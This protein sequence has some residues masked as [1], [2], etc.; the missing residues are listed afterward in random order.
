MPLMTAED[1]LLEAEKMIRGRRPQSPRVGVVLGS[2]LGAFG[3][4]LSDLSKVPYAEVPHMPRSTVVGHA[5]NLCLGRVGEVEVACLQ[6]RVH[7]Y[8]GHDLDTV[9]FGVKLLARLGC[10]AVIL[11]NA[12]GGVNTDFAPGD[13]MLITDH[14]NLTAQNPLVG[15]NPE[16]LPRFP[17]MTQAYDE[18]ILEAGRRAAKDAGSPLREGVYATMLGPSYETPTEIRML[19]TL[20][21]DAVGMSTVVEVLAL[22]HRAVRVGA[23]SCI[24]NLAAGMSGG[25]LD[26][27]EVEEVATRT[28]ERFVRVLGR[29]VELTGGL[30]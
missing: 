12:A 4:S 21:A 16:G 2:G 1:R 6:G 14:L 18:D 8:E 22:R 27:K 11:T 7:L 29:W 3:D 10:R 28:R 30:T 23:M 19:R 24:T 17:D 5:G 9:T 13:L 25:L 20:G 15:P 26:H